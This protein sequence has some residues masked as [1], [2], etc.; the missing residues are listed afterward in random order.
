MVN[1]NT[2]VMG[3]FVH[4]FVPCPSSFVYFNLELILYLGKW[5]RMS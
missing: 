1:Q 4:T 2:P 5:L 3:L